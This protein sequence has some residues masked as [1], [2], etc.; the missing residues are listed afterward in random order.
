MI[1]ANYSKIWKRAVALVIDSIIMLLIIFLLL[2][3]SV[4]ESKLITEIAVLLIV[5]L[6]FAYF[7]FLESKG[8][9]LGK[10]IM[11][12]KVITL[13]GKKPGIAR[14]FVRTIFR[15]VDILPFFYI[16]GLI[17]I[18]STGKKQR[19]GDLVAKTA[20]VDI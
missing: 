8:Q 1:Q 20:V 17:S 16:L 12:I 4:F 7:T 11:K 3:S 15:F 13:E 10:R 6:F 19:I 9:T 18:L 5:L 2:M 14:A